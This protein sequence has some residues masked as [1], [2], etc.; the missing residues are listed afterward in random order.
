MTNSKGEAMKVA[1]TESARFEPT[2]FGAV[3]RYRIMVLAFAV[4]AM[5]ASVG[6]TLMGGKTYSAQASITV[7]VPQSPQ[8][9]PA[10]YLDSQVLLLQSQDVAQR[11]AALANAS[12]H[13]KRL[14]AHDFS[15]SGG[16]VSITPPAGASAG[17]Y[18]ASIT[19]VTFTS[20]SPG[21]AQLGANA[22]IQAFDDVRTATMAAQSRATIAGIDNTINATTNPSQRA[23]LLTQRTQ[24]LVNEQLNL[25]QQPTVVWAAEPTSPVSGGWKQAALI[26]LVIGLVL[27]A[28]VAYIRASRRR[29][30]AN[31]QDPAALYG[32]P[33]IG[34]IP[35]FAPV[36]TSRSNG[37]PAGALLPMTASPHSGVAEAFRFAAGSIERIRAERGPRLSLVFVSALT[38]DGKSTVVANLALAIAEGGTRVLVVNADGD[39]TAGLL[40]GNPGADGLEQILAGQRVLDDCVQP[41]PFNGAV[42]VLGPGPASPRPVTGAARSKAA[43]FLLTEAKA[44]YDI[45][46]IDSPALLEVAN[47][48][49]LVD[50]SDAAIIVLSPNELIRDH[51]EMVERLNLIGSDVVGYI[52]NRAPMPPSLARY[53]RNGSSARPP[54]PLAASLPTVPG[55]RPVDGESGPLSQPPHG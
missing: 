38:G 19:G 6:Y 35:A 8:V 16:S 22:L 4:A 36:K 1:D 45:V 31:R 33:L 49:E 2:V 24:E 29:G 40:P 3:R 50:A 26:G 15:T 17:V 20:S 11:A 14:S 37:K 30:F 23:A 51:L 55:A 44:R 46:L 47:A 54:G 34:E 28:G 42:A 32:V 13:S 48:T 18:G 25:A 5:V 27:G 9:Q 53:Q 52:Y 43:S 21:I 7:P 10:Q 39:L 12:L 41:G